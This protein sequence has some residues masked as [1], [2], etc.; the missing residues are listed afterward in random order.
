MKNI[1]QNVAGVIRFKHSMLGQYEGY[2]EPIY[3]G[4]RRHSVY[5]TTSDGTRLAVDYYIPT[6]NGKEVVEPLPVVLQLTPYSRI[7]LGQVAKRRYG[8]ED[9]TLYFDDQGIEGLLNLVRYGYVVICTQVRGTGASFGARLTMNSRREAQDGKELIDWIAKQPFCNGSVGTTGF[10]YTGQTQLECI[11]MR[12]TALKASFVCMTDFNRYDG[13]VRGGIPRAF[14]VDPDTHYGETKEQFEAIL[15]DI[16]K[17]IMPV[18]DDADGILLHQAVR[19]HIDNCS[20]LH[21]QRDLNYRDSCQEGNTESLWQ[22]ISASTYLEEINASGVAMYMVGG[23]Y[24]VFRRDT[25]LMYHNI[26]LP[27]K[28]LM[29]PWNHM[30]IKVNVRWDIEMLRWFDYWL[31]G[32]DNGI[33]DEAPVNFYMANYNFKSGSI[34]GA[35]TGYYRFENDWPVQGGARTIWYLGLGQS[36]SGSDFDDGILTQEQ[37]KQGEIRYSDPYGIKTTVQQTCLTTNENGTGIDQVGLTFTTQPFTKDEQIVGHPMAYISFA[38]VD[39][40]CIKD[41][42]DVDFFVNLCDYDPATNQA[43]LITTGQL[44]ASMREADS[45]PPYDVQGL[46]WHRC[47]A[48]DQK[49]LEIGQNYQLEIDLMPTSY[50]IKRGHCLRVSISNSLEH[51]YYHG[52]LAFEADPGCEK[53]VIRLFFGDANGTRVVIPNLFAEE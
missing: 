30:D 33:M 43:F 48:E 19:Q 3:D 42:P 34:A 32:I 1:N 17:D 15:K 4:N 12:P 35:D 27:K 6:Q 10:S 41:R 46:P 29:G 39:P 7:M 16:V 23:V 8:R 28:L 45:N 36:L 18:D 2:S 40:G 52:R 37:I 20:Q 51:M 25:I 49:Y 11:S 13:W 14:G 22:S 24:D 38:L 5:F 53:P 47:Y 31:K 44:R 9:D 50:V 21:I 26:S